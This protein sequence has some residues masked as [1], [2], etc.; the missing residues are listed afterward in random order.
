MNG[1]AFETTFMLASRR[2]G[3]S[4]QSVSQ[5]RLPKWAGVLDAGARRNP[6]LAALP[7]NVVNSQQGNYRRH[8]SRRQ[9]LDSIIGLSRAR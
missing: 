7:R 3:A 5:N 1:R 9:C 4:L 6:A 8:W 2:T